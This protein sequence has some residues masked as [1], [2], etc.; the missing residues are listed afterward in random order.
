MLHIHV[1]YEVEEGDTMLDILTRY[2]LN[3][4]AIRTFNP[5]FMTRDMN[6]IN[7][8]ELIRIQ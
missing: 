7:V 4:A 2:R 5:H 1:F 6:K 8:G 3:F